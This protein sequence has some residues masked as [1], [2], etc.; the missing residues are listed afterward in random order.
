MKMPLLTGILT[1]AAIVTAGGAIA[2]FKILAGEPLF[3][4]VIAVHP[5]TKTVR[6]PREECTPGTQ[7]R[8]Q[9]VID[10]RL[11]TVG[12]DVSYRLGH[13]EGTVRMD[14][15]PGARIPVRNGALVLALQK[16]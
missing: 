13:V 12:Y 3:A 14:H 8:C 7:R 4:D 9:T 11:E 10:S 6:T 16:S 2:S 1:G 15:D 5:V